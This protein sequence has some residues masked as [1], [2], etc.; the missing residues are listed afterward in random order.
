MYRYCYSN[1]GATYTKGLFRPELF[2]EEEIMYSGHIHNMKNNNAKK[3]K[4]N[5]VKTTSSLKF[6]YW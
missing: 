5:K 1:L 3:V 2:W 6:L 4:L